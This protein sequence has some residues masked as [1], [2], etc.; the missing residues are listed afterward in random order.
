MSLDAMTIVLHSTVPELHDEHTGLAL[1]T[2]ATKFVLLVLA[3]S[4]DGNGECSPVVR[5]VA[6]VTQLQPGVVGRI[7]AAALRS[8][9]LETVTRQGEHRVVYRLMLDRFDVHRPNDQGDDEGDDGEGD[10]DEGST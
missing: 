6:T 7:L 4:A 3:N 10:D 2:T 1:S 9:L 8:G 5:Y